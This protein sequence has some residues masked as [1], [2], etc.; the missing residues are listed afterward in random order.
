MAHLISFLAGIATLSLQVL[1]FRVLELAIG[2]SAVALSLTL[3]VYMFGMSLGASGASRFSIP[4]GHWTKDGLAP[5]HLVQAFSAA[6]IAL[7]FPWGLGMNP[8][9]P[10]LATGTAGLAASMAAGAIFPGLAA[11]LSVGREPGF[12]ALIYGSNLLGGAFGT[13]VSSLLAVEFL[14][15]RRSLFVVVLLSLILAS[16]FAFSGREVVPE[17]SRRFSRAGPP[18]IPRHLLFAAFG[19]GF[20]GLGLEMA[21]FRVLTPVMGLS[22][23]SMAGTLIPFLLGLGLGGVLASRLRGKSDEALL[24]VG[25]GAAAALS[26]LVYV[27]DLLPGGMVRLWSFM[28]P[29]GSDWGSLLLVQFALGSLVLIPGATLAG[30]MFPLLLVRTAGRFHGKT[31]VVSILYSFNVLGSVLGPLAVNLLLIRW[32]G[33]YWTFRVL[34][35]T[36]P[37]VAILIFLNNT[38]KRK[39]AAGFMVSILAAMVLVL[40]PWKPDPLNVHSGAY[41]AS[42]LYGTI[43]E[44]SGAKL[45]RLAPGGKRLLAELEGPVASVLVLEEGGGRSLVIDGKPASNTVLDRPT[46]LMLARLPLETDPGVKKVLVIGWGSG[47]TVNE[48]LRYPVEKVVCVEISREVLESAGWFSGVNSKAL[49]DPRLSIKVADARSYLARTGETF[50]LI[51]SQ[52]SNPWVG[53]SGNLF[54]REF[55]RLCRSRLKEGGKMTQWFQTYGADREDLRIFLNTFSET[56]PDWSLWSPQEGDLILLAHP[57]PEALFDL[58]IDRFPGILL[59]NSTGADIAGVP[60]NTDDRPLLSYRMARRILQVKT[61]VRTQEIFGQTP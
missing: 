7:L 16:F 27:V 14:G 58:P 13:G 19:L 52:P 48:V 44:G 37:A 39:T 20:A 57:W 42:H 61:V 38:A 18:D 34:L 9:V 24:W 36:Y 59:G 53:F 55:F 22:I 6:L 30:M 50:D 26:T 45:I 2:S 21:A 17:E 29:A 41:W 56:F 46:Q 54:T 33:V 35:L 8:T 60:L 49:T 11:R 47:Q 25:M 12:V 5:A 23:Y 40:F 10:A 1:L 15:I 31:S 51:I 28:S 4:S 3:S 43:P 32:L